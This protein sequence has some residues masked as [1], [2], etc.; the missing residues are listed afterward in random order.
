MRRRSA[1][2]VP[3]SPTLADKGGGQSHLRTQA[4]LL[5]VI[6][7]KAGI[8]WADTTLS[9]AWTPAFAAVTGENMF[10][11]GP[12]AIALHKGRGRFFEHRRQLVASPASAFSSP[13]PLMGEGWGGGEATNPMREP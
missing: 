6:P 4:I 12:Y 2:A 9:D 11:E 13:S 3:P 7:A 1:Q 10:M 5:V 8:H